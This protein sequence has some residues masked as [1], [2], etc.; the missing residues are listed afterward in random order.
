MMAG[1]WVKLNRIADILQ[2]IGRV[3]PLHTWWSADLQ[4]EFL[5]RLDKFPKTMCITC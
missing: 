1:E 4:Q 2:E 5:A 3:S